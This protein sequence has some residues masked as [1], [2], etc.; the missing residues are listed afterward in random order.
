MCVLASIAF[1]FFRIHTRHDVM[2][3]KDWEV[4]GTG[5]AHREDW[6]LQGADTS[7]TQVA[8]RI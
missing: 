5:E 3:K 4:G 7:L 2:G 6:I 8:R 1:W